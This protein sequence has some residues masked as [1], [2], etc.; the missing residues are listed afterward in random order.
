MRTWW[1][2]AAL[3]FLGSC[4]VSRS[5]GH[6]DVARLVEQRSGYKTHWDQ[7]SLADAEVAK[8]VDTLLHQELTR[9]HAIEI[10][11]VNNRTLQATYEDLDVS[12]A[13]MVQAGLLKNPTLSLGFGIPFTPGGSELEGS[14]VQDFLDL[15]VLPLRKKIARERF[16]AEIQRVA[17]QVLQV[18]A[19]VSKQ[20][21]AVQA[22]EQLCEFR[23]SVVTATQAA[24]ELSDRLYEAGNV[25][26]LVRVGEQTAYEQAQLELEHTELDAAAAREKLNRLLG[27]W[28]PQTAWQL[29]QK[30]PELPAAEPSLEQLERQA[31]RWRLDVDAARKQVALLT[32]AVALARDFRLFGR[33]EVGAEGHQDPDGP[34]VLGPS[35]TLEL[36]IFDQRQA[37]IARLAAEQRQSEHR[38][39]ALAVDARSEVRLARAQL[40]AHRRIIERYTSRLLPLRD[41]LVEQSQLHYNGMLLGL[42]QLLTVKQEQM[43]TY[44]MYVEALRDYW[45]ARAELERAV[46]GRLLRSGE[47]S[48]GHEHE[49]EQATK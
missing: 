28:G 11:L 14:L 6:V 39:Q 45:G 21:A 23:R 2:A 9:E 31:L 16:Q 44:R 37:Q 35:L 47:K 40:M 18:V 3:L 29:A 30:L 17:H 19:E 34:R 42:H 48:Q 24:A 27:L 43:D 32:R 46:G 26:E 10:A 1:L 13:D 41:K 7:G 22:A 12:Q 20:F 38:L 33:I 4:T 49:H 15:L 8:V 36:P 5:A 25:S